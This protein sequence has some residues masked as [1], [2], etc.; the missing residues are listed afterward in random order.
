MALILIV[1]DT[2]EVRSLLRSVL[3]SAGHSLDWAD[4]GVRAL[5][6]VKGRRPDLIIADILMP[7]MD[8]YALLR[9]IRSDPETSDIP[10]LFYT[11]AYTEQEVIDVASGWGVSGV[12]LKP[13]SPGAI[14]AAVHS[15]LQAGPVVISAPPAEDFERQHLALLNAKLLKY[16]GDL[17]EAASARRRLI[18]QLQETD[19]QRRDLLAR[20]V[21]AQEEESKRIAADV[22]D[23][24]VQVMAAVSL[25]V[26]LLRRTLHEP[27]Q[28][29]EAD[30]LQKVV[31]AAG[32]RL[33]RLLFTLE[34][35][36]ANGNG[37]EGALEA[38]REVFVGET[39]LEVDFSVGVAREPP[40]Y[41]ASI[42][43]RVAQE[44]LNN[45]RKHARAS[46]VTLQVVARDQGILLSVSDNGQGFNAEAEPE[47]PVGHLGLTSMSERA[48]LAGGWCRVS[49]HPGAGTTVEFWVPAERPEPEAGGE[50]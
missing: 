25:R 18:A 46:H 35:A 50:G 28:L 47:S 33:R 11:A 45:V 14:L 6:R 31:Q 2:A 5:Q 20:I 3:P 7:D 24:S 38:L 12:L 16:I 17:E 4:T 42:L 49:S 26:A 37:L 23:D 9:F 48:R 39:G 44:A 22:H 30:E 36:S 40:D 41:L 32:V 1:D 10:F 15:V 43:Y 29:H 19:A 8:G 27:N 21:T 34:P 13:A